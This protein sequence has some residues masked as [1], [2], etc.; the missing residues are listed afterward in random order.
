VVE[1]RDVL[2]EFTLLGRLTAALSAGGLAAR[3]EMRT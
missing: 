2:A 3:V 1:P